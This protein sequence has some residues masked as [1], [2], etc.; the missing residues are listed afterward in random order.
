VLTANHNDQISYHT[1]I[2]ASFQLPAT[3]MNPPRVLGLTMPQR[4]S[5]EE[6]L[7]TTLMV[8][9][10][11]SGIHD[12]RLRYST[13]EGVSWTPLMVSHAGA[14][15]TANINPG[16]AQTVA[17]DAT[18]TDNA[19]NELAFTTLSAA[20]RAVPVRL[21]LAIAPA[22]IPLSSTPVTVHVTGTLRTDTN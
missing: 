17:L 8:A 1:T 16:N 5:P 14:A 12:V 15:Y 4:F 6:V 18:V 2:T 19:G 13:D 3:D 7:T 10:T 21:N 20:V 11:E 9:D 22:R